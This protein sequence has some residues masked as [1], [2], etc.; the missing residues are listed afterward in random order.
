MPK[1]LERSLSAPPDWAALRLILFPKSVKTSASELGATVSKALI[2]EED[3]AG[4][5]K[6]AFRKKRAMMQNSS[7]FMG[8]AK[9][10]TNE[11]RLVNQHSENMLMNRPTQTQGRTAE[12]PPTRLL[13]VLLVGGAIMSISALAALAHNHCG[14]TLLPVE[15][16]TSMTRTFGRMKSASQLNRAHEHR[17]FIHMA[18][19]GTSFLGVCVGTT[20]WVLK[21]Q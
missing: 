21:I 2:A 5:K 12:K 7:H 19:V 9:A 18:L 4:S 6:R 13:K 15:A 14:N 16:G 11:R 8:V 10:D 3:L 20:L 1:L 17:K